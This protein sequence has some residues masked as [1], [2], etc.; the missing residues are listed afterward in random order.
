MLLRADFGLRVV[1]TPEQYEWIP[2][3]VAGVERMMLD[4]V[5]DEVARATSIVRY[6]PDSQFP[7]HEHSGGEEILV[8]EGEFAD[9]HG[10]Y[11]AGSYLRNPIGTS[12][13]PSVGP[14]G[15]TIFVKLRQFDASDSRQV[16]IDTNAGEWHATR[17]DDVAQM[18]LHEHGCEHVA[19]IRFEPGTTY[20]PHVHNGGEEILVLRGGIRDAEGV[21]PQGSWMRFPDGSKHEVSSG[22]D[23]ALLYVKGGHLGT[24]TK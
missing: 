6:A 23:G 4:R 8:L 14:D 11:P 17:A 10:T 13:R 2:S 20:P 3:P 15:A 16:V 19:L 18:P 24:A 5:G 12:H 21:Y 9:E 1:V 7:P 22:A